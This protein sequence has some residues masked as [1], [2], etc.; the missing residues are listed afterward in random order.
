MERY[1]DKQTVYRI[2]VADL[3]E[4][5]LNRLDRRLTDDELSQVINYFENGVEWWVITEMA[6]DL[7]IARRK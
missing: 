1:S 6:I 4:V 2:V 5:A 3:Q 7:A